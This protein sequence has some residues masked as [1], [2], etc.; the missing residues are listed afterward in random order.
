MCENSLRSKILF[1]AV[2]HSLQFNGNGNIRAVFPS[3]L[4][5]NSNLKYVIMSRSEGHTFKKLRIIIE[6][7]SYCTFFPIY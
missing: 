2:M 3:G 7:I 4:N 5:V 6:Q 1:C